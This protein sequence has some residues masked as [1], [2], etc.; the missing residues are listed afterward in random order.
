MPSTTKDWT[1]SHDGYGASNSSPE[2]LAA[3]AEV[4]RLIQEN[5]G[6]CLDRNWVEGIARLI[7]AQLAHVHGFA[8]TT[9]EQA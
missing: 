7:V 4:R 6:G 9:K 1:R 2:F 8:P 3:V 5:G